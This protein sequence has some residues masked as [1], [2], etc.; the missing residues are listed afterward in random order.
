[1]SD[2]L[3]NVRAALAALSSSE[4]VAMQAAAK[5]APLASPGLLLLLVHAWEWERARRNGGTS[6]LGDPAT[7]IATQERDVAIDALARLLTSF[8]D[9]ANVVGFLFAIADA[10]SAQ[11]RA[12]P[13]DPSRP[14]ERRRSQQRA[15]SAD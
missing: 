8:R 3:D 14:V 1:V 11:R 15:A 5:A 4:L 2:G 7:A 12:D 9:N 6:V 13:L 10:L